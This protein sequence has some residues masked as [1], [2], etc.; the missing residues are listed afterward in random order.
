[1]RQVGNDSAHLEPCPIE[2]VN[3]RSLLNDT[4]EQVKAFCVEKNGIEENYMN[5]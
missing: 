4:V 3:V 1:M 5:V 2:W